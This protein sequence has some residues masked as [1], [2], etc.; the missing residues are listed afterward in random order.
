M[1]DPGSSLTTI[2]GGGT[3]RVVDVKIGGGEVALN[4]FTIE[5]GSSNSGAGI[6]VAPTGATDA[7]VKLVNLDVRN[8]QAE[9]DGYTYGAGVWGELN[10]TEHLEIRLCQI[11]DNT[12]TVTSGTGA[13]AGAGVLIAASGDATLLVEDSWVED[14]TAHSDTARKDGAGHFFSLGDNASGEIVNLRV[15]GNAA[16]GSEDQV[17]GSGGFLYLSESAQVVVRRSVWALNTDGTGDESEQL[18]LSCYDNSSL[19]LTDSVAGLGGQNGLLGTTAT[20]AEMQ[21]VNLTVVDNTLTGIQL[22]EYHSSTVTLYNSIAYGN[23]TDAT[24]D[25]GVDTGSSN[26]IGV[27]PLFMDPPGYNYRLGHGSPALNVGVNNPPGGLGPTDFDGLPR[28]EDLTVDLGAYEGE[29]MFF[30]DGFEGGGTGEWS[31]TVP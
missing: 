18:R 22:F 24:L 28:L 25:P 3:G 14:N 8:N 1:R 15:T 9:S 17:N 10:G 4:G 12:A 30:F 29:G 16:S 19:L 21:L 7:T 5:N 27:D 2:D 6:H 31:D 23:G 11:T 26:L 20:T 13:A